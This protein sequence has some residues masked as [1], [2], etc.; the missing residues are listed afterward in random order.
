MAGGTGPEIRPKMH[1]RRPLNGNMTVSLADWLAAAARQDIVSL[2]NG[3]PGFTAQSFNSTP[4]AGK[5]C[6]PIPAPVPP[7]PGMV[8]DC[9]PAMSAPAAT[10]QLK[11]DDLA[12][13]FKSLAG[14]EGR[15]RVTK[16][17]VAINWH[18]G[19]SHCHV[20]TGVTTRAAFLAALT[21]AMKTSTACMLVKQLPRM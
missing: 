5:V 13:G 9:H 1:S 16:G 19:D 2:C 4:T 14:C 11:D 6:G 3:I 20:L 10:L 15:C 12:S 21:A 18:G 17:C 8:W 7:V